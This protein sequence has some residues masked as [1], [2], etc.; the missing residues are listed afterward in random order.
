M[1]VGPS[2]GWMVNPAPCPGDGMVDVPGLEPGAG[3]G[4]WVRIPLRA[5]SE[6][7]HRP[8]KAVVQELVILGAAL[9]S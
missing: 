1:L 6:K 9:P 5:L 3:N 4:V 2:R 8:I 7:A